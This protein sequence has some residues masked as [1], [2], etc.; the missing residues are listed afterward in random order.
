MTLEP[1]LSECVLKALSRLPRP[2]DADPTAIALSGLL[3]LLLRSDATV[4]V[5]YRTPQA[6]A[7]LIKV[8]QLDVSLLCRQLRASLSLLA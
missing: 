8:L 3:Q 2:Q 4:A 1:T 6:K 7:G 5:A